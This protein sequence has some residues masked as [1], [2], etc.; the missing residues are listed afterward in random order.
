MNT[1][2]LVR[3]EWGRADDAW[4]VTGQPMEY[5]QDWWDDWIRDRLKYMAAEVRKWV[6][7]WAKKMSQYWAVRTGDQANQVN[8]IL[9]SLRRLASDAEVDHS[10]LD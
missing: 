2:N 6:E 4:E 1:A 5:V 3:E 8:E 7:E 10:G 9:A